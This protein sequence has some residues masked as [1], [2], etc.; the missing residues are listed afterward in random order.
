MVLAGGAGID[1]SIIAETKGRLTLES[2]YTLNAD[3]FTVTVWV[4]IARLAIIAAIARAGL[5]IV[6]LAICF[7]E[8]FGAVQGAGAVDAE[9]KLSAWIFGS[10][11]VASVGF[12]V[13]AF[14]VDRDQAA[15]TP[16]SANATVA[17]RSFAA[18][19]LAV[20]TKI[21]IG[22]KVSTGAIAGGGAFTAR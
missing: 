19:R 22:L 12:G 18:A 6:T 11:A 7:N 14:V 5:G 1:A 2:A 15:A 8:V 13:D 17:E 4:V 16:K 10:A 20:A 3:S 9:L 21:G